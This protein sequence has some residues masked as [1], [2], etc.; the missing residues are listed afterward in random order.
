MNA[1][2][3]EKAT[4]ATATAVA[5]AVLLTATPGTL[6]ADA[7]SRCTIDANRG[8]LSANIASVPASEAIAALAAATGMRVDWMRGA[9]D[10]PVTVRFADERLAGAVARLLPHRSYA[11]LSGGDRRPELWIGE[12]VSG[13]EAPRE[14]DASEGPVPAP[15]SVHPPDGAQ[16]ATAAIRTPEAEAERYR[17]LDAVADLAA[18]LEEPEAQEALVRMLEESPSP[19]VRSAALASLREHDAVPIGAVLALAMQ[20]GPPGL[21]HPAVELLCDR[22][23]TDATAEAALT[24]LAAGD[25]DDAIQQ[26]AREALLGR[27]RRQRSRQQGR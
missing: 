27:A 8:R 17:E 1:T 26:I 3:H 22:L 20:D 15:P 4:L 25:V 7:A 16:E 19:D 6:L 18:R 10:E 14:M 12:I 13:R 5:V 11:L 23:D 2:T 24:Q 9:G 21:R